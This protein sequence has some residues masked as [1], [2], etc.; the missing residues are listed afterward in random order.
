L[1]F[2]TGLPYLLCASLTVAADLTAK[3]G[4]HGETE[5]AV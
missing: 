2:L 4:N 5:T 1:F 3:I